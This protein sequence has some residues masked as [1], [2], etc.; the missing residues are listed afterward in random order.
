MPLYYYEKDKKVLENQKLESIGHI[1]KTSSTPLVADVLGNGKYQ[2]IAVSEDG[3]LGIFDEE[4]HQLYRLQLASGSETT[5]LIKDV[6]GDGFLEIIILED[7]GMISCYKT[8]SKGK[9]HWGQFRGDNNNSGG[10]T[11]K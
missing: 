6:D 4:G 7:T 8:K 1:G 5:P 11:Q 9:I 2:T 3:I 10:M